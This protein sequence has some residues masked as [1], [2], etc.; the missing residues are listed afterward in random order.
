MNSN[1]SSASVMPLNPRSAMNTSERHGNIAKNGY[2]DVLKP[3]TMLPARKR[4]VPA[5]TAMSGFVQ[6][7]YGWYRDLDQSKPINSLYCSHLNVHESLYPV[8]PAAPTSVEIF[9]RPHNAG[10]FEPAQTRRICAAAPDLSSLS[11]K[12]KELTSACL[13]NSLRSAKIHHNSGGSGNASTASKTRFAPL[14]MS[15]HPAPRYTSHPSLSSTQALLDIT[16]KGYPARADNDRT[17]FSKPSV[18]NTMIAN[19]SRQSD[20]VC[21]DYRIN[22]ATVLGVVAAKRSVDDLYSKVEVSDR[23]ADATSVSSSS[24]FSSNTVKRRHSKDKRTESQLYS[25]TAP[26]QY[27]RGMLDLL[28]EATSIV[29]ERMEID[30]NVQKKLLTSKHVI[31]PSTRVHRLPHNSSKPKNCNCPRSKCIKLYCECFQAGKFCSAEC[32]CKKCKNTEKDNGPGGDRTRAIQNI[33]SRNPY[34]FQKEKQLFEK[35]NPDLVGVNCRCVKSQCLKLY[36]DCFQSGKICGEHCMCV[37]CL[38]TEKESGEDGKRTIARSL[39]LLRKPHAFK[40]KVKVV[41]SG[42]SCKN[43]RCLKKYC[44]CFDAGLSCSSKC[45]CYKC[46]NVA[47]RKMKEKVSI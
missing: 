45:S 46:E 8:W 34:A 6:T 37:D 1:S 23:G 9:T 13:P 28:C 16:N 41:G 18:P 31:T 2:P 5:V 19:R 30:R 25:A 38:N 21:H 7:P 11:N 27:P 42:C 22:D 10:N 14:H 3:K 33:M 15:G 44:A 29:S 24:S 39:C 43:S 40:K 26:D 36:C 12:G 32:C 20:R 35:L 17:A 4:P 47:P